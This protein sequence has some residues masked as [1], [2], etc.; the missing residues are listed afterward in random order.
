MSPHP[1]ATGRS[2]KRLRRTFEQIQQR[3]FDLFEQRG[4]GSGFELADWFSAE[5]ELFN[6]P[7]SELVE[8]DTEFLL[9]VAV[10]GLTPDDLKI[11]AIRDAVVIEGES[12]PGKESKGGKV[13][14]REFGG[15]KIFRKVELPANIDVDKVRATIAN[16]VLSIAAPKA[17]LAKPR[18]VK[19]AA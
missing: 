9:R 19:I 16:G 6:V 17:G 4:A 5:R 14:L 10:P 1:S 15:R 11:T 8:K 13:L 3:A 7:P 12:S 18:I 2:W